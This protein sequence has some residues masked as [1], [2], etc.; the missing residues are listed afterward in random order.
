VVF[1]LFLILGHAFVCPKRTFAYLVKTESALGISVIFYVVGKMIL[2]GVTSLAVYNF[3]CIERLNVAVKAFALYL[4]KTVLPIHLHM[5]YFMLPSVP[6]ADPAF[7][8]AFSAVLIFGIAWWWWKDRVQHVSLGFW[9][10]SLGIIPILGIVPLNATFSEHWLYIP[11]LGISM[12][13]ALLYDYY[14]GNTPHRVLSFVAI[15]YLLFFAG[16]TI[17]RNADWRDP[18]RFYTQTLH[19]TPSNVKI[20][21]NLG[22]EYLKKGMATEAIGVYQKARVILTERQLRTAGKDAGQLRIRLL[23]KVYTNLG[24]AYLV[25]GNYEQAEHF[26]RCAFEEMPSHT[27]SRLNLARLYEQRGNYTAAYA[28]Y[29]EVLALDPE[30]RLVKEKIRELSGEANDATP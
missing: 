7:L 5:E 1:P 16:T 6:F 30:N 18:I 25:C 22:N 11:L 9:W 13:I 14:S 20:L 4:S 27:L 3:S 15:L 26:Y 23:V 8:L 28:V 29:T 10:F 19:Y 17:M 12:V 2:Q 21:Y 24:S